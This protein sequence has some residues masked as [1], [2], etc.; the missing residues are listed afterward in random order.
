MILDELG[1]LHV[2][3]HMKDDSITLQK[4]DSVDIGT[5]IGQMGGQGDEDKNGTYGQEYPRHVHYEVQIPVFPGDTKGI[6][7]NPGSYW[8]GGGL[9]CGTPFLPLFP[10]MTAVVVET[11]E[12]QEVRVEAE[13]VAVLV[14]RAVQ[15][16]L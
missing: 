9:L 3:I 5:Q 12:E 15:K 7:I 13:A 10:Q 14:V 11:Q 1:F 6:N 8:S 16:S 2:I 4:G